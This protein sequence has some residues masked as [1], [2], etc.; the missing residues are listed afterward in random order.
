MNCANSF[1]CA[2][3]TFGE[4]AWDGSDGASDLR[5]EAESFFL[6]ENRGQFA[7]LPGKR[8]THLPGMK[9]AVTAHAGRWTLDGRTISLS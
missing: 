2:S 8:E 3:N 1:A 6:G 4:V 7:D 5:G 9:I